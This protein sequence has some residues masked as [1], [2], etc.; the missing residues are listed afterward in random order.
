MKKFVPFLIRCS[1]LKESSMKN[2][3]RLLSLFLLAL[4]FLISLPVFAYNMA[5][6]GTRSPRPT[7]T[8]TSPAATPVT[9][10]GQTAVATIMLIAD[11]DVEGVET[12]VLQ[13][14]VEWQD[15]QGNWHLVEGWQAPFDE[16]NQVIW[17][18]AAD[19]YGKGP[20]RWVILDDG[21]MIDNSPD[22]YLPLSAHEIK[23]THIGNP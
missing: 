1:L 5:D 16:Y 20:F 9:P 10:A 6:T 15:H 11:G 13:T 7:L 12:A 22:F 14:A 4:L 8:P 17:A 3:T 19:A 2:I 23:I 18:V 21:T